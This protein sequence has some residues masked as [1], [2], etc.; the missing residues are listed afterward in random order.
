MCA[1][2]GPSPQ[3][4]WYKAKANHTKAPSDPLA[5]AVQQRT[6]SSVSILARDGS[7]DV[8]AQNETFRIAMSIAIASNNIA[9]VKKLLQ[10]HQLNLPTRSPVA[11]ALEYERY[12]ILRLLLDH[13]QIDANTKDS[14]GQTP[15]H[16]AVIYSD[17][18]GVQIL[19][20][21]PTVDVNCLTAAGDSALLLA[22]KTFDG[23]SA[24][25]QILHDI[26]SSPDILLNQRDRRGR[27]AL[28][29]AANTGNISLIM[30]M[31]QDPRVRCG[32]ADRDGITPQDRAIQR[33]DLSTAILFYFF[34]TDG[35]GGESERLTMK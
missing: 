1:I 25:R 5:S 29:H 9:I 20:K 26:V 32:V 19:L 31:Y 22:A 35:A 7:S 34:N 30:T 33:G 11:I 24:Q 18:I 17:P 2:C 16:L 21:H 15:L 3:P 4:R 12:D 27:S 6:P 14:Q 13:P 8:S 28:W 10:H 23:N